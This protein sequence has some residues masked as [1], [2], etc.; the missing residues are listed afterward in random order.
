MISAKIPIGT[1]TNNKHVHIIMQLLK[2][3]FITPK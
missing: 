2:N 3:H 1:S